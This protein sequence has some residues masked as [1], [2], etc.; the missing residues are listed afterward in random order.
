LASA[1]QPNGSQFARPNAVPYPN[2]LAFV[3]PQSAPSYANPPISPLG[4][5]NEQEKKLSTI[6]KTLNSFMQTTTQRQNFIYQA[7]N[8]LELQMSRMATQ[9]SERE[10][11]F[12]SQLVANPKDGRAN[13]SGS[14]QLNAVH[15]L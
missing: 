2:Q 6:K 9:I 12:S 5:G 13:S 10:G 7:I 11:A 4:F 15:T 3:N 8:H 1:T 14:A